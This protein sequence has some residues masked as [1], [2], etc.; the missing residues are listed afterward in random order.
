MS[1]TKMI[2]TIFVAVAVLG[3]FAAVSDNIA[4]MNVDI[5]KEKTKQLEIK[6]KTDSL[7]A[8]SKK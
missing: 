2:A 7:N 5:E 3:I 8:V 6:F 4:D 1:E